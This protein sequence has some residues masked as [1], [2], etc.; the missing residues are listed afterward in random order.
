LA[1]RDIR[2]CILATLLSV[3][4]FGC[5]FVLVSGPPSEPTERT[6]DAAARCTTSVVYPVLDSV[7]AGVGALNMGIAA[8]ASPGKVTWYGA[9]MDAD[10]GMA[11]GVT[12]LAIFGAGAVYGFIQTSRCS[13][14]RE[15]LKAKPEGPTWSP[16]VQPSSRRQPTQE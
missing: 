5:S 7:G 6:P 1:E 3:G 8:S 15:E 11:L 2:N 12:Q 4:C 13:S 14:L 16:A 10:T 9:E